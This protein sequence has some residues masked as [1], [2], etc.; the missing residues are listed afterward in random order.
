MEKNYIYIGKMFRISKKSTF[1][2]SFL[3][4]FDDIYRYPFDTERCSIKMVIMGKNYEF[5]K[6]VASNLRYEGKQARAGM[7]LMIT[8]HPQ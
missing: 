5:T 1:V 2:G 6:I 7:N 3:C 4:S 8:S